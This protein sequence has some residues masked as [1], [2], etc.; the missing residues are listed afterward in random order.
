MIYYHIVIFIACPF[1]GG[2]G[3]CTRIGGVLGVRDPA[4]D[5]AAEGVANRIYRGHTEAVR[6]GH[7]TEQV[8][9]FMH[10]GLAQAV[11]ARRGRALLVRIPCGNRGRTLLR[12]G[13]QTLI[14][15]GQPF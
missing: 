2:E 5:R 7:P 12:N 9:T 10:Q 15:P 14:A 3:R 13:V 6:G 4:A 1:G 8:Q 11:D